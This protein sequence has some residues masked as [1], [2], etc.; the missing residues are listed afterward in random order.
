LRMSCQKIL[1]PYIKWSLWYYNHWS[2]CGHCVMTDGQKLRDMQLELSQM[3][4]W[5]SLSSCI[6]AD[7]YHCF[8]RI[9][10]LHLHVTRNQLFY[11]EDGEIM[12]IWKIG[13]S[14]PDYMA[15][16]PRRWYSSLLLPWDPQILKMICSY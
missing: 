7:Q 4:W 2:F 1:E 16:H 12:F 5:R 6:L 3:V 11:P 9:C 10:Y 15:S 14:L 13:N 8:S